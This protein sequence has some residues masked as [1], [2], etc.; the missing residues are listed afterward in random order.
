M[1]VDG[2]TVQTDWILAL[3]TSNCSDLTHSVHLYFEVMATSVLKATI[4]GLPDNYSH[5]DRL[6]VSFRACYI[7]GM[8]IVQHMAINKEPECPLGYT[9]SISRNLIGLRSTYIPVT[10]NNLC[11]YISHLSKQTNNKI[12]FSVTFRYKDQE[13][14]II[15]LNNFLKPSHFC[16]KICSNRAEQTRH[17]RILF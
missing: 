9:T 10:E 14:L 4:F 2:T 11:N 7:S 5:P 17:Q 15:I 3:R 16:L 8:V 13:I 12:Y 1:T 6:D